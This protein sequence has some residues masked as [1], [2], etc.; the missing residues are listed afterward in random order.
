MTQIALR[1]MLGG[2]SIASRAMYL[3]I[4]CQMAVLF[5]AMVLGAL[6]F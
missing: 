3:G 6:L 4:V 2:L 5:L 1:P